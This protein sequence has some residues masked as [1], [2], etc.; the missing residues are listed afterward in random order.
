MY[1]CEALGAYWVSC[2]MAMVVYWRRGPKM[3]LKPFP[4]DLPDFLMYSSGKL[5]CRHLR[6]YM[7]QLF[8]SWLSVSVGA[9]RW[10]LMVLLLM[11]CIWIPKLLQVIWNFSPHLCMYGMPAEIFLLLDPLLL[12]LLDWLLAVVSLLHS[13]CCVYG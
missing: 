6:L 10:V 7:T 12:V 8:W 11:K 4:N 5:M 13:G 2:G 1:Y 9:T 3:F